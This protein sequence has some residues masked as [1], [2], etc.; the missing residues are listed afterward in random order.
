MRAPPEVSPK[1]KA[2]EMLRQAVLHH[3]AQVIVARR[4][5]NNELAQRHERI[6]TALRDV[7]GDQYVKQIDIE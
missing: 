1:A 3:L 6:V 7:I 4:A 5:G 2:R